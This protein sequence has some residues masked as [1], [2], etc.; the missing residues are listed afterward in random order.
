MCF[1]RL[2]REV[3]KYSGGGERVTVEKS[4]GDLCGVSLRPLL[5]YSVMFRSVGQVL[6][7][8]AP[9]QRVRCND[10]KKRMQIRACINE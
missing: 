4:D 9:H 1:E 2:G 6:C 8:N 3:E 10:K 5:G 7:G